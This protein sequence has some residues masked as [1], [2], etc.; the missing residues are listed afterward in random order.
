[1]RSFPLIL[2]PS[3]GCPQI[4]SF[5]DDSRSSEINKSYDDHISVIIASTDAMFGKWSLIPSFSNQYEGIGQIPLIQK[6]VHEI[7]QDTGPLPCSVNDTR[8]IMSRELFL[9]LLGGRV[10]FYKIGLS[11]PEFDKSILLRRVNGVFRSTLYDLCLEGTIL[12]KKPHAVCIKGSKDNGIRFIHLTD[13]HLARRNDLIEGE[14]ITTTG[15]IKGFNNFNEKMRKFIK[16]ANG[17]ADKG[18]LDIV[19][20]SGDLVDFVNHGVSDEVNEADNNWQVFIE[21]VTGGGYEPQR[22][23]SGIRVPIF[24][25]TGNHDWR[26]HPYD[27]V[28]ASSTFG[29]N[30]DQAGYF[31]FEYY[32]TVERLD[33]KRNEVYGKIVKKGSPIS[34]ENSL[35]TIIKWLLSYSET[36]QAKILVPAISTVVSAFI[37]DIQFLA[38][39]HFIPLSIAMVLHHII[40]SLLGKWVIYMITHAVLPIEASVRS[41]HYYFLHINPYFNYAFSSGSNFFIMMDTGPDCLTGQ[42]LWDN[43]NKK[44]KRITVRDNILG[45]S[46]DSMAF[47]PENEYYSCGQIIWLERVLKVIHE[48]R[49]PRCRIFIC[50]H[51][52]P[53]NVENLPEIPN[54]K[55][56]VIL[57]K[58]QINIRH[59][60]INHYLSQFFHLCLGK[61]ENDI[62]YSGPK[63][64]IVFSGHAH[65]N[66]EF[67]IDPD[68]N[69]YNGKYSEKIKPDNFDDK[70]PFVVQTAACGP[71]NVNF[72]DPPYFRRVYVDEKGIVHQGE[73]VP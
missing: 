16:E 65:Q 62:R 11:L 60:T 57:K 23:N 25:S 55:E 32:D 20:I 2:S 38:M 39:W 21:I 59:G 3:L 15:Q 41:L 6:E 13:L 56:E 44:M 66:V 9:N 28:N 54:D 35:H 50:L 19:L 30:K 52:P 17:I 42:Y 12:Q 34:K 7:P 33:S 26:L 37:K 51:A 68:I 71:L 53:I 22:E 63:V 27:I 69:I 4:I 31:D 29:I 14:I 46:P 10:Q 58:G 24:T 67:R 1:M 40:N 48:A 36:W 61:K 73:G 45:G 64:D 49:I 5:N 70:R 47:Y 72:P 18:E 8:E 43:G